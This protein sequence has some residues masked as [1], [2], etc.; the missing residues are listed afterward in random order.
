MTSLR[1]QSLCKARIQA[2]DSMNPN[3]VLPCHITRCAQCPPLQRLL[4]SLCFFTLM[5][6]LGKSYY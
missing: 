4:R 2:P 5:A 6:M 3:P 1:C